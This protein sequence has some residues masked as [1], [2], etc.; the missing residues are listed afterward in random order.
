MRRWEE[1]VVTVIVGVFVL[2]LGL[3]ISFGGYYLLM[4]MAKKVFFGG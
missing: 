2:A 4:L 1:N 3:S